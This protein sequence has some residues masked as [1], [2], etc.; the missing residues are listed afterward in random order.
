MS[1]LHTIHYITAPMKK[2]TLSTTFTSLAFASVFLITVSACSDNKQE[3]ATETEETTTVVEET[4]APAEVEEVAESTDMQVEAA[5]AKKIQKPVDKDP[6]LT[7]MST[8]YKDWNKDGNN[9]LDKEEFY[10]GLYQAWDE[11]K[12]GNIEENEFTDGVNNFFDDY[13][14]KEYGQYADWDTD[15]SGDVSVAEFREGMKGTVDSDPTAQDLLVIWD[16]DNDPA[17]ERIE[18][19]NITVRLD[20]DSN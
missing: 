16:T 1:Y 10:Q 3:A 2:P 8:S 11:N 4:P 6:V 17:I 18:L 13:N 9:V 7:M 5:P 20:K 14:F 19:D 12:D 15:N